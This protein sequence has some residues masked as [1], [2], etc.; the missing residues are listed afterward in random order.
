[1]KMGAAVA[2]SSASCLRFLFLTLA[3]AIAFE[4]VNEGIR[5][6][7]RFSEASTEQPI[8]GRSVLLRPGNSALILIG[9][10]LHFT[11]SLTRHFSRGGSGLTVAAV[12]FIL[13]LWLLR[14]QQTEFISLTGG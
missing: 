2:A 12:A 11:W 1:M 6:F 10:D 14:G 3:G 13:V 4:R 9:C 5:V 8:A 7:Q